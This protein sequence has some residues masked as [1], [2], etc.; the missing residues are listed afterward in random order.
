MS[1]EQD[2]FYPSE[3]S[4][5]ELNAEFSV[6]SEFTSIRTV[7]KTEMHVLYKGF[8]HGRIWILKGLQPLYKDNDECRQMLVKEFD[9]MMRLQHGSIV[10]AHSLE[11]IAELGMCIIMEYINGVTLNEWLREKR[12]LRQR[13]KVALELTD[14]LAFIN[15]CG[16]VHRDVKPENIMINRIGGGVKIIDFGH[17]DSDCH[18]LFKYPAGTEGFIS[19]QQ[20][21]SSE[22]DVRNDIYSFGKVLGFLLPEKRFRSTRE[23]CMA[24]DIEHRLAGFDEIERKLR[25]DTRKRLIYLIFSVIIV[26]AVIISI[27]AFSGTNE[28]RYSESTLGKVENIETTGLAV[29]DDYSP[30]SQSLEDAETE[31]KENPPADNEITGE[32]PNVSKD[33]ERA[34]TIP[35]IRD[36]LVSINEVWENTAMIYLDT[37]SNIENMYH[38]WSTSQME[39]IRDKFLD[40]LPETLTLE[41]RKE[42][43]K[44]LDDQIDLN[45][46]RWQ[47]RRLDIKRMAIS[48]H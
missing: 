11:N 6:S 48:M 35:D 21:I 2:I 10:A 9:I 30:L 41:E 32:P 27:F 31:G 22:P 33:A 3:S 15:K 42:I 38:D 5:F 18:S 16:I 40:S 24:A 13:L 12:Q 19:P 20:R 23:Q 26:L 4:G 36:A 14:A 39:I 8:R 7:S 47:Q 29:S 1:E 45:Y 17:A 34:P 43:K 28:K 25:G 46:K 44:Q 37:I